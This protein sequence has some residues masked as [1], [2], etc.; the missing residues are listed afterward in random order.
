MLNSRC[1]RSTCK[2]IGVIKRHA[3]E[4][5]RMAGAYIA[6]MSN[7]VR[8]GMFTVKPAAIASMAKTMTLIAMST[9][10]TRQVP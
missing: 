10:V 3:S 7:S 2:N 5:E 4:T 9:N 6:P 1:M 8:D